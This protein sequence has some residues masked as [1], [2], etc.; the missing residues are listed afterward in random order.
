MR[1]ESV[2]SL[3]PKAPG[4]S[5]GLKQTYLLDDFPLQG[6]ISSSKIPDQP[7][8]IAIVNYRDIVFPGTALIRGGYRVRLEYVNKQEARGQ[9]RSL[10]QLSKPVTARCVI[11]EQLSLVS[12]ADIVSF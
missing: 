11:N 3:K 7:N 10:F 8:P 2:S 4:P 12:L 1:N 5:R 6:N 9:T